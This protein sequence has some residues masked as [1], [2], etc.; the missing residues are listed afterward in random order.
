MC[1]VETDTIPFQ[2]ERENELKYGA[3]TDIKF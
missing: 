2:F 1:H 3:S